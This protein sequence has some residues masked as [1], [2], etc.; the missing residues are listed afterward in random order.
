MLLPTLT[1]ASPKQRIEG[2]IPVLGRH[3]NGKSAGFDVV[4]APTADQ[5]DFVTTIW[6]DV[7]SGSLPMPY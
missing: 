3:K 4:R 7:T 2:A 6:R 5:H 1:S